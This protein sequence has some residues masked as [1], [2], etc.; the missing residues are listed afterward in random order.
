MFDVVDLVV[1]RAANLADSGELRG[2]HAGNRS[3]FSDL[4]EWTTGNAARLT[5]GAAPHALA[6][7]TRSNA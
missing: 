7:G 3:P 5:P 1:G 4:S 6:P 2:G